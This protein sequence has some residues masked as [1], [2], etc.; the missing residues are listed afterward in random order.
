MEP[1]AS[2]LKM[3]ING[4]TTNW[5]VGDS[6]LAPISGDGKLSEATIKS[7]STDENGENV[8][9]LR[10]SNFNEEIVPITRL[11]KKNK[12]ERWKGFIFDDEDL[13]K[14]FFYDKQTLGP[15]ISLK[16][17]EG[18]IYVPH[19]INRYLRDYQRDGIQF[20]CK[21]YFR[22]NG[23]ILGDD[24]GLGKTVQV[25]SFLAAVLHKT[26]TREDIENNMPEFVLKTMRKESKAL[27][28]KIFLVIAPLSVLYNW[29][30]E[31]DAWG[32]FR[33]YILHGNKKDHAFSCI[34][35]NKC[36]IALS[37][38]ETVR[39]CLDDINSIEWSAVF[40]D[41][42]HKIKNP[43]AQITQALKALKCKVR[44]GLTG[45]ILQNNMDELWCV[46]DWAIPGC[47]GS[48]AR[49]KEDFGNPI[50]FGQR[51]GAT[52]RELAFG[53][54]SVRQLAKHMSFWF[55]R[56]TKS[57]ISDQLPRKEDRVVYCS[58]TEFQKSVYKAVLETE[59]IKLVMRGW[60]PCDCNSGRKRKN[61]CY[62]C[63]REG[64]TVRQI[65][66]SY[67]AVL[68]KI[69]NHVALLQPNENTSKMQQS[70]VRGVCEHVFGK[71]PEFVEQSKE[72][73]FATISDPKYSGKMK[74]LQRLLDH[75]RR[76]KDKVL[77]F[78][79]STK[80]LDVLERHC[81]ATGLDYRRLDGKTKTEER[82]KIVKE[83]NSLQD[84]NICLV[85]TMAGGLGLN[86]VGANVVIMFDPTWNPAND[87]QAIDRA[88]RIGQCRNVQVFRLISLG[89]VEEIIYLRQL[90]KQQ[91]HCA[92][93]GSENARRYFNAVQGSK[94]HLGEIFGVR[95]LFS[96]RI[97]GSCLTRDII[98]REG[99]VEAGVMTAITQLR[100]EPPVE[101]Q[102]A[103]M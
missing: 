40:V 103:A 21:H 52:K 68:R 1:T 80:L 90:Y 72:A 102:E 24:M 79:F 54:K 19:T 61:C 69:S 83:F 91:L 29:K 7:I 86:F 44:I 71:F 42:A 101:R 9:L 31:L 74:V 97:G 37:T 34:R 2:D 67:L 49:F 82:V 27:N 4:S 87:L 78:S 92:A 20:I 39:L 36:E 41:E 58:L 73:A 6:V 35:R 84:I 3:N 13:E 65:Y 94:E 100:E 98:Q 93:V 28:D 26:G 47:L 5:F 50:E 95:N 16:L 77:L 56:R 51:H 8:A 63:N 99:Q 81:M 96:L 46:M 88:Y 64:S 75:F 66:F 23:C 15:K 10:F 89:T 48:R 85:S 12:C 55:L 25:I 60:D 70:T 22:G 57:L 17:C 33:V 30:N 18:G 14:P 38:Y 59:D 43:K 45:T 11:Q 32:Y 53:R 76:N 62:K